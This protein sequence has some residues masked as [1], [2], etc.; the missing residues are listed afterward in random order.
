MEQEFLVNAFLSFSFKL[1]LDYFTGCGGGGESYHCKLWCLE[2]L[3]EGKY[4]MR[5]VPPAYFSSS[6]DLVVEVGFMGAPTVSHELLSNGHECLEA[7]NTLEKFLSKKI[8]GIYSAEIGGSNGLMGLLVAASKQVPCIDCDGMGRAFP[9]LNQVLSFI[10]NLPATPA[11]LCDIRGETVL[12]TD[13]MI[14]T[15]QELEDVFRKECTERGLCVGV[16]LPPMNGEQL[17]KHALPYSLSRAW[18]LGKCWICFCLL[19]R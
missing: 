7:V 9:Y 18:F 14:S 15:A 16:C 11:C 3:R 4:K 5:V 17:Q 8:A 12:C 6:T 13:D 10:H 19:K 2:V 1:N